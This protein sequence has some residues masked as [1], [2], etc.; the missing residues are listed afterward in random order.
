MQPLKTGGVR[1]SDTVS[2]F[3]QK[4]K[5]DT[6]STPRMLTP[7]EQASLRLH[8]RET[9]AQAKDIATKRGVR[10]R[11]INDKAVSR[12]PQSGRFIYKK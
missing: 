6:S 5:H 1:Y 8:A 2:R 11:R 3:L 9:G 4:V 12:D 7:S 10:V